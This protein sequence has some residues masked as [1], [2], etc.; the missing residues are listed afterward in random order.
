MF[1]LPIPPLPPPPRPPA[2][3]RQA[4]LSAAA[5][6]APVLLGYR[7][8]TPR[9]A[10]TAALFSI[11]RFTG[12]PPPARPPPAPPAAPARARL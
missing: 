6:L 7:R 9:E 1:A 11:R 3:S 8:P 2:P 12:R 4:S 5:A 10:R